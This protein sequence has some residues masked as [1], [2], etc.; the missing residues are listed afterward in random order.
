MWIT[1]HLKIKQ[2]LKR[3]THEQALTNPTGIGVQEKNYH[4]SAKARKSNS[5]KTKKLGRGTDSPHTKQN[6]PNNFKTHQQKEVAE[7]GSNSSADGVEE[8][9]AAS[10]AQSHSLALCAHP[11]CAP[12]A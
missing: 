9:E 6:S 3:L 2:D 10:C 4:I 7:D 1:D 8:F 11:K 12:L 5:T